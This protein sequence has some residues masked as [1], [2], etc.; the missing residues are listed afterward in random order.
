MFEDVDI[1]ESGALLTKDITLVVDKLPIDPNVVDDESQIWLEPREGKTL[2]YVALQEAFH[3]EKTKGFLQ[4][5]QGPDK[6]RAHVDFMFVNKEERGKGLAK[7][8]KTE[9]YEYAAKEEIA[10]IERGIAN[11]LRF[12]MENGAIEAN[13]STTSE[14]NWISYKSL[15]G[16]R[17]ADG[18]F[19][20]Q[21]IVGVDFNYRYVNL[22]LETEVLDEEGNRVSSPEPTLPDNPA[23]LV[24]FLEKNVLPEGMKLTEARETTRGSGT[25]F[26]KNG[27]VVPLE[28]YIDEVVTT[29]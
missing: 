7:K 23:D 9:L 3:P 6:K 25:M 29:K 2:K 12:N 20:K 15:Q 14:G 17:L 10:T 16:D 26:V 13:I 24:L 28:E 21:K 1:Q 11:V 19:P 8:I 18:S 27:K 5:S 4:F 22:L